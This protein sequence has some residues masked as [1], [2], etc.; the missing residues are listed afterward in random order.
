MP[1]LDPYP[2]PEQRD[3]R[4]RAAV[5]RVGGEIVEYGHSVEGRALLAGRVPRTGSGDGPARRVLI[6]ASIH[7]PEYV[8]SQVALGVLDRLEQPE[9]LRRLR[10]E[11]EI[12][13]IPCL[14]PDAYARV[15]ERE[16]RG[17]MAELRCNGRGVDLNR[18]FPLPAGRVRRRLPGAGS[19]TPGAATYVGEAPLSEPESAALARLLDEQRFHAATSG[20]SFAG[21]LIPAHAE[22]R[23]TFAAYRGLCAAFSAA[24]TRAR[25]HRLAARR[26]DTFTGELEDF[27]HHHHGTWAVCVETFPA[28]ASYR[29][30]LRAPSLFWRMNPRDPAPWVD[31]DVPGVAAFLHAAL[32]LPPAPAYSGG[33]NLIRST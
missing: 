11:A 28:L 31:N 14:N 16:G 4:L 32:A 6:A 25:Y 7:G 9:P 18:N 19:S 15:W 5:A 1:P 8:S 33:S 23:A 29:Q 21:A 26:L 3:A 10:R 12:W 30:H 22:D 27:H 17:T 13:V 24:Q 20:H 2:S